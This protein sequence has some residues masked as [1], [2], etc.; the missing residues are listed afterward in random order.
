MA[1]TTFLPFC[2]SVVFYCTHFPPQLPCFPLVCRPTKR[3]SA[4]SPSDVYVF[5][6]KATN[7]KLPFFFQ[8]KR[9]ESLRGQKGRDWTSHEYSN[10]VFPLLKSSLTSVLLLS[11]PL[12]IETQS[13]TPVHIKNLPI[14]REESH[15]MTPAE[16]LMWLSLRTAGFD[17]RRHSYR[18]CQK[19][20]IFFLSFE[21]NYTFSSF[22][23][24][25]GSHHIFCGWF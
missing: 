7:A 6:F 5:K 10:N 4:N 17:S 18:L 13:G 14:A 12:K 11:V 20:S 22:P 21:K 24:S 9:S 1:A 2:P 25:W 3:Q 19:C 8:E 15:W 16:T 23:C